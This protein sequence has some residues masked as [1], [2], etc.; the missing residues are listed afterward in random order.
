MHIDPY[1]DLFVTPILPGTPAS[2]LP[3]HLVLYNT[4]I[5]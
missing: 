2:M 5:I 1:M 3:E 4:P